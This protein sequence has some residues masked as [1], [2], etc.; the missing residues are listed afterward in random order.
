MKKIDENTGEI[1]YFNEI[2][3]NKRREDG[4]TWKITGQKRIDILKV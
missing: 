1:Q 2:I 3:C 4:Q